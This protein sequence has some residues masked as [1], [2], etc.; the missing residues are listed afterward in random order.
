MGRDERRQYRER[1]R[2]MENVGEWVR[3]RAE[4]Q[5]RMLERAR[6]RGVELPEPLFGQQLMTDQE[7]ERLRERLEDAQNEQERERIRAEHREEMQERARVHQI[8]LSESE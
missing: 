1:I 3:F 4:H 8:P 6:E 2:E 5:A 7:R